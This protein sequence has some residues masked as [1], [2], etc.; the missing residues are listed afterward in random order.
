MDDFLVLIGTGRS[1]RLIGL[2]STQFDPNSTSWLEAMTKNISLKGYVRL[3]TDL[4]KA[5]S[6]P[7][8][9]APCPWQLQGFMPHMGSTLRFAW[10]LNEP[11]QPLTPQG[12]TSIRSQLIPARPK[13]PASGTP[14]YAFLSDV[15]STYNICMALSW[16]SSVFS[17]YFPVFAAVLRRSFGSSVR[18]HVAS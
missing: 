18:L 17:M 12:P 15:L 10:N 8:P 3:D 2:I 1:G 14:F 4:C 7:G 6:P 5:I 11:S 9:L 16:F 13:Y